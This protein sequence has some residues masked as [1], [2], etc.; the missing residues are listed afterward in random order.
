MLK[1]IYKPSMRFC[2]LTFI[3]ILVL[4]L[5]VS[6]EQLRHGD[7]S[8]WH[9]IQKRSCNI[10]GEECTKDVEC[11][12]AHCVCLN[13]DPCKCGSRS[14]VKLTKFVSESLTCRI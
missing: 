1:A 11:C 14:R 7:G 6:S 12:T 4:F 9:L 2:S 5:V 13:A 10:R 8:R 3:F